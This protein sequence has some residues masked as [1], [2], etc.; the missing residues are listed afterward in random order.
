MDTGTILTHSRPLEIVML[1]PL[2]AAVLLSAQNP[3][4]NEVCRE[5]I[6]GECR[7][8]SG[9]LV[10]RLLC[11]APTNVS[12]LGDPWSLLHS[13]AS[14]SLAPESVEPDGVLSPRHVR[15][16]PRMNFKEIEKMV[17]LFQY[18]ST[19]YSKDA[20]HFILRPRNGIH[21]ATH[22]RSTALGTNHAYIVPKK[23]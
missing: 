10:F 3:M 15:L 12:T 13:D 11:I 23:C 7:G 22:S 16:L 21:C 20:I 19:Q 5:A 14:T 6:D 9:V 8:C 17:R 2:M 1:E 4:S 18:R